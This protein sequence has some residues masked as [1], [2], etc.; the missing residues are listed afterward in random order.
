MGAERKQHRQ[1]VRGVDDA[2]AVLP[3]SHIENR[4]GCA[5]HEHDAAGHAMMALMVVFQFA[6]GGECAVLEDQW[7]VVSAMRQLTVDLVSAFQQ[8]EARKPHVQVPARAEDAVIVIPERCR[9]SGVVI[10]AAAALAGR[11]CVRREAIG[12]GPCDTAVQ[13]SDGRHVK[14]VRVRHDRRPAALRFDRRAWKT[15]VITPDSRTDSWQDVSECFTL[16]DLVVIRR[17][18]ALHGRQHPGNW[19]R[20]PEFGNVV[21]RRSESSPT[22]QRQQRGGASGQELTAAPRALQRRRQVF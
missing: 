7:D 20:T 18:V 3:R 21:M 4:P 11:H 1:R 10:L 13:M 9:A 14:T 15:S 19:Q 2:K 12:L 16:H 22:R 6:V 8:I 5:V 17:L